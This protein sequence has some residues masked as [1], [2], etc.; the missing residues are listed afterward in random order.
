MESGRKIVNQETVATQAGRSILA[1]ARACRPVNRANPS[2]YFVNSVP[3][4]S[5]SWKAENKAT[6]R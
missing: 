3:F 1:P 5:A 4:E 2:A 6:K